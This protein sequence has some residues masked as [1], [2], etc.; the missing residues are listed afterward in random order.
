MVK[1]TVFKTFLKI[2]LPTAF[3][4][5]FTSF[6]IY[7]GVQQALRQSANSPQA[8]MSQDLAVGLSA[9]TD[10]TKGLNGTK[11]D[12]AKSLAPF[13]IVYDENGKVL[14]S[15]GF[16][17]GV[18]PVPPIGVFNYTKENGEDRVSWQTKDGT[19][20]A[21]VVNHFSGK[22]PGFVLAGRNMREVENIEDRIFKLT[23]LGWVS[24]LGFALV[25]SLFLSKLNSKK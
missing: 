15:T 17:N 11:V 16:I 1:L 9:G 13:L 3:V 10:P 21:S 12:A 2:F 19:R 14:S 4:L 18:A 20:I 22:T 23:M 25:L 8:Q 6:G 5:T 7:G 24:S